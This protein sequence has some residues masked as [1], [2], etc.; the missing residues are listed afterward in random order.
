MMTAACQDDRHNNFMIVGICAARMKLH[1]KL[2]Q[3]ETPQHRMRR[4]D[5]DLDR[6]A[7]QGV[8]H[9]PSLVVATSRLARR[10]QS[11]RPWMDAPDGWMHPNICDDAVSQFRKSG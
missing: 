1:P 11:A 2:L 5:A 9:D 3:T 8:R 4:L 6:T 10:R 7:E